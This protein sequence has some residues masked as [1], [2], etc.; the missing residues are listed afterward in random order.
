MAEIEKEEDQLDLELDAGEAEIDK[1]DD[2]IEELKR[3]LQQERQL[4]IEAQNAAAFANNDAQDT[5][6]HLVNAA[7]DAS[8]KDME[9]SKM[10]FANALSNG[11]HMAAADA[12]L[13][14]TQVSQQL[15]QLETG[16]TALE[17]KPKAVPEKSSQIETFLSSLTKPSADWLR[18]HPDT[19]T[20]SVLNRKMLLAHALAVDEGIEVDSK[21]YFDLIETRLGFIKKSKNE[22]DSDPLSKSAKEDYGERTPAAAPVSRGGGKNAVRLSSEER[23]I[24]SMSGMTDEEYA[25]NKEDIK[26]EDSRK[27]KR[28]N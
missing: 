16:K 27:E 25:R 11:D 8:K 10:A 22:D 14:M 28:Y 15:L 13:A 21:D 17:A 24:A 18:A 2:G 26:K 23:E 20:N 4:R 1:K 12:Q 3:Q 9:E 6:L 19:M 7:I 5:N